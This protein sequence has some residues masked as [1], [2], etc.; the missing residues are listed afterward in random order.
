MH[1]ACI[2]YRKKLTVFN[3]LAVRY[4]ICNLNPNKLSELVPMLC[5]VKY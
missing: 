5:N 4:Q 3:Y 2:A 1:V